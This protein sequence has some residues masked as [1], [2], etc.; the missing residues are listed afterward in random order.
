MLVL[1]VVIL[2][3]FNK[4]QAVQ[5]ERRLSDVKMIQELTGVIKDN[6]NSN[7]L[8]AAKIEEGKNAQRGL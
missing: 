4:L 5:E 2:K 1:G 8:V 3:L 7:N 6:T